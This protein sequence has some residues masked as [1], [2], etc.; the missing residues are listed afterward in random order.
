[1]PRSVLLLYPVVLVVL[2]GAPR[3]LY[4]FWKDSRLD[5]RHTVA[6]QRVLI[7]RRRP[8]RRDAGARPAPRRSLPPVGLLD[9]NRALRGTKVHGVPVLGRIDDLAARRARDRRRRC[10]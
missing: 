2:L 6:L 4:R 7:A 10:W 8:R 5:S 9:D 3:L 1:M